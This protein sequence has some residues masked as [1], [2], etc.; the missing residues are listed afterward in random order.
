VNIDDNTNAFVTA[1]NVFISDIGIR[2]WWGKYNSQSKQM[3]RMIGTVQYSAP[4]EALENGNLTT[5]ADIW[6]IGCIGYELYTGS[7]L[8]E[9]EAMIEH[10][11]ENNHLFDHTLHYSLQRRPR[12]REI[13]IGC[14]GITEASRWKVWKLQEKLGPFGDPV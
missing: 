2:H 12:I 5:A 11:S 7:R 14:L 9:N 6:A 10:Y 4:P 1:D 8:F 3:M 13:L